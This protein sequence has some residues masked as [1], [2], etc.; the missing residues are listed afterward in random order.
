MPPP[1]PTCD[2]R[3]IHPTV[4]QN[5]I[6]PLGKRVVVRRKTKGDLAPPAGFEPATVGLEVHEMC[7][8]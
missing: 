6:L 1:V 7:Y 5:V 3:E 4:A 2:E 8:N